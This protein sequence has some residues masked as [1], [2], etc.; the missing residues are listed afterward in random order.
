[1][2]ILVRAKDL[3]LKSKH[4]QPCNRCGLCCRVSLCDLAAAFFRKPREA[5]G[6][7]PALRTNPDGQAA[8]GLVAAPQDF[9]PNAAQLYGKT[10]MDRAAAFLINQ[11]NGCDMHTSEDFDADYDIR[12]ESEARRHTALRVTAKRMWGF[13]E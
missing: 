5:P 8:C 9:Y 3:K 6:P 12:M 2:A 7:C 13:S 10:E 11:G 1:M 4:G